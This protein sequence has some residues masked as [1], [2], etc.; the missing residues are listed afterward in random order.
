MMSLKTKYE[1]LEQSSAGKVEGGISPL[2][3]ENR[4][5]TAL[6]E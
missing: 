3:V 6:K 4:I 2:D 5:D 1:L